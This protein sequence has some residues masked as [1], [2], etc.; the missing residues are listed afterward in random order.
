MK[1]SNIALIFFLS[2]ALAGCGS[3]KEHTPSIRV[4]NVQSYPELPDIEPV[5]PPNLVPWI[6]D[7]PRDLNVLSVKNISACR[8]VETRSNEIRPYI[9]EPVEEQS[10]AWWQKCGENPIIPLSNIFIGFDIE[11]WN[12]ILENFYKLKEKVWQYEQR[13][14]EINK[15][16]QEWREKAKKERLKMNKDAEE[17][18]A[19]EKIEEKAPVLNGP[20]RLSIE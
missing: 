4:I 10:D 7:M 8:K 1:L 20:P 12:T 11:N 6:H 3:T 16:R 5:S 17:K 2:I 19:S 18:K 9:T 15:Q 14:L 13:I